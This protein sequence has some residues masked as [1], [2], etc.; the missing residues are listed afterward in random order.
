[1]REIKMMVPA[2]GA[3]MAG[4]AA[5]SLFGPWGRINWALAGTLLLLLLLALAI[6]QTGRQPLN[7]LM[8]SI[9]ATLAALSSLS[10]IVFAGVAN[11]QPATFLILLSGYVFG[12]RTGFTVGMLTGLV[13]NFFLGHGPWTPWQ[14][15]GW[16]ICGL[17]G[18][19]AGQTQTEFRLRPFLGLSV[20]SGY[21]FGLLMNTWHWLA[22]VYP[23]TWQ[24][25]LATYG[26]SLFFDTL[27]ALGNLVFALLFGPSF[28]N[29]LTRF[30][31]RLPQTM[32]A[33]ETDGG[34][35]S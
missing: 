23:L 27:H 13:S 30:K 9:T 12:G 3:T 2:L 31:S 19:I 22:L 26:A 11:V 15:I 29:H 24:T 1:M 17:L 6:W 14:M 21:L 35:G 20:L 4:L 5:I 25:L 28:F 33:P 7:V 18:G 32:R 34:D 8:I 16:G 10:R